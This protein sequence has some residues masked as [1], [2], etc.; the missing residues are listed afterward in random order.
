M[1]MYLNLIPRPPPPPPP[2]SDKSWGEGLGTR[3]AW[4]AAVYQEFMRQQLEV[5]TSSC[6][7]ISECVSQVYQCSRLQSLL[8]VSSMFH[9]AC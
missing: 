6:I 5:Y 2:A 9:P 3:P 4:L 1:Y 7:M 8:V